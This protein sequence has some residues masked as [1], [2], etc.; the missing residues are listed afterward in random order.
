MGLNPTFDDTVSY[1]KE[2]A[3]VIGGST[4]V[5]QYGM[6]LPSVMTFLDIHLNDIIQPFKF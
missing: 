2:I 3:L 6:F 5:G 4:S 1:T